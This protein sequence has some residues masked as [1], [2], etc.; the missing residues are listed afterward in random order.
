[1]RITYLKSIFVITCLL[2][3]LSAIAADFDVDGLY[4]NYVS[5]ANATCALTYKSSGH[6]SGDIVIPTKVTYGDKTYTV[7]EIGAKAFDGCTGVTSMT[8]PNSV[9][10]I[11]SSS[12]TGCSGLKSMTIE[13]GADSL[14]VVADAFSPLPIESLYLGRNLNAYNPFHDKTK[15][16]ALTIGGQVTKLGKHYFDNCTALDSVTIKDSTTKLMLD[17]CLEYDGIFKSCPLQTVYLGRNLDFEAS[18]FKG[19]S[20]IRSL[21]AGGNITELN[22]EMF[23]ECTGLTSVTLL[24]SLV[25]IGLRAFYF[26]TS[27]NSITIPNSVKTIGSDAFNCCVSMTSITLPDSLKIINPNTFENCKKLSSIT[28]PNSVT[29]IGHEAF[30]KCASIKS[31]TIP[32]SVTTIGINIATGCTNLK[33]LILEDGDSIIDAPLSAF[34]AGAVDSLYVGRNFMEGAYPFQYMRNLTYL[35]FGPK[36]T[37]I[38]TKSFNN[39]TSLSSLIIPSTVNII[40]ESAFDGCKALKKVVIEPGSSIL[41]LGKSG[42]SNNYGMFSY[43][44]LDSIYVGRN[45]KHDYSPFL[46]QTNLTY[47]A[48]SDSVTQI[49]HKIFY[50]CSNLER[51]DIPNSVGMIGNDAFTGTKWLNDKPDGLVYAGLVA[52]TYKGTMPSG[53]SI[54]ITNGTKGIAVGAFSGCTDLASVSIPNTVTNIGSIAFNGCSLLSQIIIPNSVKLINVK[55]FNGC[56]GLKYVEIGNSVESIGVMAFAGCNAIKMVRSDNV[57]APALGVSVGT[58]VFEDS[59]KSNAK[60]IIPTGYD[61]WYS[62]RSADEWKDFV[63][64]SQETPTGAESINGAVNVVA[65][66]SEITISGVADDVQ[67]QVYNIEGRVIYSGIEKV[68]AVPEN[69][70]YIVKVAGI[71]KKVIL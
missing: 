4:Y 23:A 21:T 67:V 71:T 26:C 68:I 61:A 54:S 35:V 9:T 45:L 7:V 64:V 60:L 18:P 41:T 44:P 1:M 70:V 20:E 8:I 36:A 24:N 51:I 49:S 6:Y 19:K 2:A 47:A 5:I 52:Y 69:G 15:L 14:N 42:N 46:N 12:F 28:I 40:K 55:S 59:V 16:T 32:A 37:E 50:G 29:N 31:L 48:F 17:S 65:A 39:C 63:T 56:T 43:C 11:N 66:G 22:L 58:S 10:K 33:R 62:Y 53:T 25:A 3:S 13:D 34:N 57:E 27:L 38:S 30:I